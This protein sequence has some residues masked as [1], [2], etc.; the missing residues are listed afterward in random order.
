MNETTHRT[1]DYLIGF[2][3]ELLS[4]PAETEWV[5]FKKETA[6]VCLKK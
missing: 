5:E 4:L 3:K 6:D 1:L 2:F